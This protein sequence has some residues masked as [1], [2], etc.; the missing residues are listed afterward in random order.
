MLQPWVNAGLAIEA[1]KSAFVFQLD[2]GTKQLNAFLRTLLPGLFAYFDSVTPGFRAIQD[3]PD[4]IGTKRI[5]YSLPYILLHKIRKKYF[6]VDEA[7]P[8]GATY[9]DN[10]AGD[11]TKGAGFRAKSLFL[12]ESPHSIV[13]VLHH[14]NLTIFLKSLGSQSLKA[15]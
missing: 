8:I 15:S 9:K 10:L 2:W 12:G 14:V 1:N 13:S 4:D 6:V 7:H 5:D 3:E 11:Q